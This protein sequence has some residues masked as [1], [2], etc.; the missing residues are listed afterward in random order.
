[1]SATVPGFQKTAVN[2]EPACRHDERRNYFQ[3]PARHSASLKGELMPVTTSAYLVDLGDGDLA[4]EAVK[5][6]VR[7]YAQ[8]ELQSELLG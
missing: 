7:D 3:S 5:P 2:P 4:S 8:T 6:M 1:M